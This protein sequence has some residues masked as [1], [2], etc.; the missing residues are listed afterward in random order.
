MQ[1]IQINGSTSQNNF[2]TIS[3]VNVN[4]LSQNQIKSF[5]LSWFFEEARDCMVRMY[6]ESLGQGDSEEGCLELSFQI[7]E[8]VWKRLLKRLWGVIHLEVENKEDIYKSSGK[9]SVSA[10]DEFKSIT[11]MYFVLLKDIFSNIYIDR[12]PLSSDL[13]CENA[14]RALSAQ[15]LLHLGDLCKFKSRL[16]NV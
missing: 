6:Q 8:I 2:H 1:H 7:E 5:K 12:K 13:K 11:E 10:W 3:N 4:N 16:E 14:I 15:H 9:N